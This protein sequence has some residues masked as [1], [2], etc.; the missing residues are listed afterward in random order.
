MI[1]LFKWKMFVTHLNDNSH[2][3]QLD[4]LSMIQ[5]FRKTLYRKLK[6]N[7]FYYESL[8]FPYIIELEQHGDPV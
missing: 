6:N 1:K 2:L 7:S 3:K 8:F 4:S 5:K